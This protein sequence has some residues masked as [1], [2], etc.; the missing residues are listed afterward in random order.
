MHCGAKK[1]KKKNVPKLPPDP[2][3]LIAAFIV[4]GRAFGNGARAH[5]PRGPLL[6]RRGCSLLFD[7]V[8][9]VFA[10]LSVV[11]QGLWPSS[12]NVPSHYKLYAAALNDLLPSR[13]LTAPPHLY[14]RATH[15]YRQQ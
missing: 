15:I 13:L 5:R 9:W 14:Y 2:D 4:S 10:F 1:K 3:C 8:K 11:T 7:L 6:C 12:S